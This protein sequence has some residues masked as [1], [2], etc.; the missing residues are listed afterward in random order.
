MTTRLQSRGFSGSDCSPKASRRT[1]ADAWNRAE[2]CWLIWPMLWLQRGTVPLG[3]WWHHVILGLSGVVKF[4]PVI[5]YLTEVASKLV[6]SA[7]R[8][9]GCGNRPERNSSE[10]ASL[11]STIFCGKNDE[12]Q[13]PFCKCSIGHWLTQA[14]D[15]LKMEWYEGTKDQNS[16]GLEMFRYVLTFQSSCPCYP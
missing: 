7:S 9:S 15:P 14:P 3:P 2:W 4:H 13:L 1:K 10:K 5:E 6:G 16:Q 12:T 8:S 11:S